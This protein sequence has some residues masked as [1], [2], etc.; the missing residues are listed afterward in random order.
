MWPKTVICKRDKYSEEIMADYSSRTKTIRIFKKS[1]KNYYPLDWRRRIV[2]FW[3]HEF[4]H[5]LQGVDTRNL[6]QL[7]L[8]EIQAYKV[9]FFIENVLMIDHFVDSP[10][11][12]AIGSIAG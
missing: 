5:F 2:A 12:G 4:T 8:E 1:V 9:Q 7:Y 10:E 11:D 6:V 3:F